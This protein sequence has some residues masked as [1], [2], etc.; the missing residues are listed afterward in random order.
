MDRM[1]KAEISF[2][3]QNAEKLNISAKEYIRFGI[4]DVDTEKEKN[5]IS[6]FF[7]DDYT[8]IESMDNINLCSGGEMEKLS[9]VRILQKNS[10]LLVLDEPT[11]GLDY[12]SV[13]N[14]KEVLLKEKREKIII[15][16]THDERII[17]IY[18]RKYKYYGRC[19]KCN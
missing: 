10:S 6:C 2:L 4:D 3:E 5:L 12:V 19:N 16:V 18:E 17:K 1:L 15:I 9:L 11:T 8:V 7:Q 13:N 14:L